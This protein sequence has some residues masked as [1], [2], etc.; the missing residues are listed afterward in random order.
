MIKEL[1]G[2]LAVFKGELTD[3]KNSLSTSRL[4]LKDTQSKLNEEE[5]KS[6]MLKENLTRLQSQQNYDVAIEE[7][8]M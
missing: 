4:R 1:E 5:T 2:Q 3:T 8:S 6:R 7:L